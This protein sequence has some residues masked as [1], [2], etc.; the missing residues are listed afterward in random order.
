[1]SIVPIQSS[2]PA[3][4]PVIPEFEYICHCDSYGFQVVREDGDDSYYLQ[5]MTCNVRH[6]GAR[7]WFPNER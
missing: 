7:V 5:C 6:Y 1:M 4:D 3:N 2:E